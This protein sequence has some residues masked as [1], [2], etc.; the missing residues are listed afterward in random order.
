MRTGWRIEAVLSQSQAFDGPACDQMLAD[1]FWHIFGFD[2]A[3]PDR[4]GINDDRR[5]ML[6]LVE[7]SGLVH[8]DALAEPHGSNRIL[9]QGMD[10]ALAVAGA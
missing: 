3:I 4:T 5:P 1:D 6:T 7:A 2:E 10:L 9:E 8:S